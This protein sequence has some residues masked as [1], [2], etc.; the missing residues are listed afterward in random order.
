MVRTANRHSVVSVH[1]CRPCGP[2]PGRAAE[3]P[4]VPKTSGYRGRR[5]HRPGGDR[6]VALRTPQIAWPGRTHYFDERRCYPEHA[7]CHHLSN[8]LC[9]RRPLTPKTVPRV[10]R[11]TLCVHTSGSDND[12]EPPTSSLFPSPPQASWLTRAG[13]RP[14]PACTSRCIKRCLPPP[15]PA[16]GGGQSPL[17]GPAARTQRRCAVARGSPHTCP[18]RGCRCHPG[19]SKSTHQC[20]TGVGRGAE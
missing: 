4:T 15:P 13:G 5:C 10:Y 17:P 11:F 3:A 7:L 12:R 2:L 8:H 18:S 9:T 16:N 6:H 20:T 19:S 1:C 14:S